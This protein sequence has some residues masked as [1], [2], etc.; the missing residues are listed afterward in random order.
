MIIYCINGY[1]FV[2]YATLAEAHAAAK[3]SKER[4]RVRIEQLEIATDRATILRILN[5]QGGYVTATLKAWKL[6]P[7]GALQPIDI[8]EA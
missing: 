7:R 8:T 3:E 1:E 6:T 5:S 2:H 4:E